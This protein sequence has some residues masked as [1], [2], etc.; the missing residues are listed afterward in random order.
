MTTFTTNKENAVDLWWLQKAVDA[1]H[2]TLKAIHVDAGKGTAADGFRLHIAHSSVDLPDGNYVFNTGKA[3]NKTPKTYNVSVLDKRY[4][5][6]NQVFPAGPPVACFAINRHYLQDALDMP[7]GKC[8]YIDVYMRT[9]MGRQVGALHITSPDT[10]YEALIYG[11][12]RE[13]Q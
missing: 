6:Y 7:T 1:E 5:K 10:T 4:P 2:H 3:L 11:M 13:G 8:V 9:I 12:H